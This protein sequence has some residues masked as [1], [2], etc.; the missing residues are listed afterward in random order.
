MCAKRLAVKNNFVNNSFDF[1]VTE[2][3]GATF[4]F[5]EGCKETIKILSELLLILDENERPQLLK[6][7]TTLL[8]HHNKDIRKESS[9]L[10]NE[11]K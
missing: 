5:S 2:E 1:V 8:F 6:E 7:L 3:L 10:Y 11:D 4:N 9:K